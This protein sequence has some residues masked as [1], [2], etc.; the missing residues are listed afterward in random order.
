MVANQK[1]NQNYNLFATNKINGCF[2]LEMKWK[3]Y[4]LKEFVS[5]GIV[6]FHETLWS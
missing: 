2:L 4:G 1:A 6:S 5:I 3:L